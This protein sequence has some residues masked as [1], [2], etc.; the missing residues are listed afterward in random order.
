MSDDH[1]NMFCMSWSK[2]DETVTSAFQK[3]LSSKLF[4]N[5]TLSAEG[6][7][8]AC[9]QELLSAAST[10]FEQVL[11]P[12][13]PNMHPIIVLK[14]VLFADLEALVNFIYS[15]EITVP[16]SHVQ[17]II[18]TGEL[19]KIKGLTEASLQRKRVEKPE[20]NQ[21][22]ATIS[23][24]VC[25][26][27]DELTVTTR[28]KQ[29][30]TNI[31]DFKIARKS[32]PETTASGENKI[33]PSDPSEHSSQ[34]NLRL[35]KEVGRL[36]RKSQS[37]DA[38]ESNAEKSR[39]CIAKLS[40]SKDEVKSLNL[41][42]GASTES[43]ECGETSK[44]E[45]IAGLGGGNVEQMEDEKRKEKTKKRR[46]YEHSAPVYDNRLLCASDLLQT[47]LDYPGGDETPMQEDSQSYVQNQAVC[48]VSGIEDC[49]AYKKIWSNSFLCYNLGKEILCLLCF[50]RF[51]QFKKFNLDRHMRKKHPYY[52][53]LHP[54]VKQKVLDVLVGRYEE[55]V[56]PGV[57]ASVPSQGSEHMVLDI[58]QMDTIEWSSILG[59]GVQWKR[60]EEGMGGLRKEDGPS[61][62]PGPVCS[63]LKGED[64]QLRGVEDEAK[65]D[66]IEGLGAA[67]LQCQVKLQCEEVDSFL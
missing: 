41:G 21:V 28:N 40:E 42:N 65:E 27:N 22:P 61:V 52:Y 11:S 10:W 12:L 34:T 48:P 20:E 31:E 6:R 15:G 16:A 45:D 60:D 38:E 54:G 13:Q 26:K 24:S 5:V 7:T 25:F 46:V 4:C 8:L 32:S 49:G 19:L 1:V 66:D 43:P 3:Y 44:L 58:L 14:D 55:I 64:P 56:S 53:N 30:A 17:S 33:I 37:Q 57:V 36:K 47:Q 2:Y 62:F 50:C 18:K 39:D 51:T 63:G 9:H 29:S 59:D 23:S 67:Y 35:D